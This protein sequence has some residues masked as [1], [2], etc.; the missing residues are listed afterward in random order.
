MTLVRSERLKQPGQRS[1]CRRPTSLKANAGIHLMAL[2]RPPERLTFDNTATKEMTRE[3]I[4]RHWLHRDVHRIGHM[5]L[6]LLR[7]WKSVGHRLAGLYTLVD[8]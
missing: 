6:R 1:G 5:A 8:R 7:T 4:Y 3:E 2:R